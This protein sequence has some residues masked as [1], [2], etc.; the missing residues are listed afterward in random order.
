MKLGR[1]AYENCRD[2]EIAKERRRKLRQRFKAKR[3]LR[4]SDGNNGQKKDDIVGNAED[5]F[6]RGANL[7]EDRAR[8]EAC[9]DDAD[10]GDFEK[11]KEQDEVALKAAGSG[12]YG[13]K[14][15]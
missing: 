10:G 4:C 7:A 3:M 13:K 11:R 6:T 9:G 15:N 12:Q 14:A 1:E 2:A 8:G 5:S